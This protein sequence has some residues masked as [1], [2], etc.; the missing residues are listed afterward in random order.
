MFFAVLLARP[1]EVRGGHVAKRL[2][3]EGIGVCLTRADSF[4]WFTWQSLLAAGVS[5]LARNKLQRTC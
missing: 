2:L 4:P 5:I 3:L 1:E